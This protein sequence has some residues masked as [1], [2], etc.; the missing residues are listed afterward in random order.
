MPRVVHVKIGLLDPAQPLSFE[1]VDFTLV[2]RSVVN[3][4]E[5]GGLH[6]VLTLEEQ[7]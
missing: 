4:S 1:A 2:T 7:P 5:F 3:G 6:D